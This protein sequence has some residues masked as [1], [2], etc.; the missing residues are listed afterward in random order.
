VASFSLPVHRWSVLAQSADIIMNSVG[1][2]YRL[3]L[4]GNCFVETLPNSDKVHLL[5]Y[6]ELYEDVVILNAD[7]YMALTADQFHTVMT[8]MY[9]IDDVI[10][11]LSLVIPCYMRQDHQNQL[12]AAMCFECNPPGLF[13]D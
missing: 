11:E 2:S 13:C 12:G 6:E 1:S 10:P 5:K 9:D 3:H 7:E 4:G 8:K